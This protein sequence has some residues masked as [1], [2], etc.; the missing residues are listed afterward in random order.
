MISCYEFVSLLNHNDLLKKS[1]SLFF[2]LSEEYVRM[3]GARAFVF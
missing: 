2:F 3:V 1:L